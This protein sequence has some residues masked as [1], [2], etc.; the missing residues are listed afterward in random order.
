MGLENI[1][2]IFFD[3][4]NTLIDHKE[5]EKQALMS[6]FQGIGIKYR[7]E[8]Q[9]IFRPLDRKLWD[10]VAQGTNPVS[11]KE[12]PE[13]R[14]KVL[15]EQMGIKYQNYYRANELFKEGLAASSALLEH[16]EEIVRYLFEKNYGLYIVTNGK[17]SLQRPRVMNSKIAGYITDIIVSEEAGADKPNPQIFE[18]LLNKAELKPEQV[19]MVGDSL[20]KDVQGSHNAGIRAIWFNRDD[21]KNDTKVIPEYEIKSL[22][23]IKKLM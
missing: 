5:C 18:L 6:M 4:D 22:L 9:E 14:F 8:Y 3:A 17:V 12:I 1:K 2:A 15:F 11:R 23:E 10:S 19:L 21:L 13:Y 7:E 20:D 16:A